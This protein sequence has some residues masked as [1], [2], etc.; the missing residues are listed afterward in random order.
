MQMRGLRR[1]AI[2]PTTALAV[3]NQQ[4]LPR[5]IS[6][7]IVQNVPQR[8]E[9]LATRKCNGRPEIARLVHVQSTGQTRRPAK[10]G[11]NGTRELAHLR[12]RCVI[13]EFVSWGRTTDHLSWLVN[14]HLQE[15]FEQVTQRRIQ[16]TIR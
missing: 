16:G 3:C 8:N 2:A 1:C 6:T 11:M 9:V 13:A 12:K 4:S 10:A 15:L 7:S 5:C 14:V